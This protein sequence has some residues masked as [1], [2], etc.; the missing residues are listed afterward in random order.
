MY[1]KNNRIIKKSFVSKNEPLIEIIPIIK[2]IIPVYN[3]VTLITIGDYKMGQIPNMYFIDN[4]KLYQN[5]N[6]GLNPILVNGNY[7]FSINNILN[8]YNVNN[9]EMKE[10]DTY[11]DITNNKL[12]IKS[13]ELNENGMMILTDDMKIYININ[14]LWTRH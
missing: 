10:I 1:T 2:T 6:I 4:N 11:F 7:K 12:I 3:A 5:N 13:N 9:G 8:V 14:N